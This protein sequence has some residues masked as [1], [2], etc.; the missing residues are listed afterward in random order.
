VR[1][2]DELEAERSAGTPSRSRRP[3]PCQHQSA[4][5]G[6]GRRGRRGGGRQ[7]AWTLVR[8]SRRRRRPA[9]RGQGNVRAGRLF[10][11]RARPRPRRR[12]GGC[13]S[14]DTMA[15]S[16]IFSFRRA[17][18]TA[19]SGSDS[20]ARRKG[21]RPPRPR[22]E[23]GRRPAQARRRGGTG[24]DRP[25]PPGGPPPSLL[26]RRS[27]GPDPRVPGQDRA[28][29]LRTSARGG[30]ERCRSSVATGVSARNGTRPVASSKRTM[31]SE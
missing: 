20:L 21:R 28:E 9:C 11:R 22:A 26:R 18:V 13:R 30:A 7:G 19:R 12:R 3:W 8:G 29:R 27:D 2:G 24:R 23:H 16:P 14:R 25:A 31:P 17:W 10:H 15:G 1:L 5:V 4:S 6:L